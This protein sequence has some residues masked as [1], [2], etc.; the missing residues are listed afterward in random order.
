VDCWIRLKKPDDAQLLVGLLQN[1]V[2]NQAAV[3]SA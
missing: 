1:W 2:Q 3:A